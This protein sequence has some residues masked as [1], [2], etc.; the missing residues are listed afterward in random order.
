MEK[1]GVV[2]GESGTNKFFMSMPD[3]TDMMENDYVVVE[4]RERNRKMN[5][6][7]RIMRIGALSSLLTY[8]ASYEAIEKII[9]N[10]IDN[11]KIYAVV[12][13]LGYLEDGKVKFPRN[14][15]FPGTEVYRA[16]KELLEEFY[17][18]GKLPMHIGT[19]L[20]R[21]DVN[22]YLNPLGFMRHVAIIAQTGGGK[23]YTAGVLMEELYDKGA[24]IVV[25]DPHADYVRMNLSH[26]GKTVIP[27]FTVFRNPMSV[28]RYT[29]EV[30]DL[31]VS[32]NDLEPE[33]VADIL[34]FRANAGKMRSVVATAI[35][36]I[37]AEDEKKVITFEE[38][39]TKIEKW[40]KKE[41]KPPGDFKPN[42]AFSTLRVLKR[43]RRK[44][45]PAIFSKNSTPLEK[46]V[47]KKHIAVLDLSGLKNEIQEILVRIFLM[48]IYEMNTK[49]DD[50]TPVF[51]FIEEAHNF[52]PYNRNPIS[53]D[54]I[55]KIAAEGRKFG[56]FLV[57]ISQR[58]QKIDPDV[59]SQM[60]SYII[61]R[62]VNKQ[63]IRALTTAAESLSEDLSSL[64]PSLNPGEAVVVGPVINLPGIVKI[65][66]RKTQEGG[67]D[68]DLISKL[69]D[70][71]KTAGD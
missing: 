5:V 65:R 26:D 27:R 55:K 1:V 43:A 21:E 71:N 9:E 6:V 2:V 14:P 15:P 12:E 47:R 41:E 16:P 19:L 40:A 51:V 11:P 59:L 62:L 38:L 35:D 44:E 67:G 10:E 54:V 50:P 3:D 22:I 18:V 31:T 61:L 25:I 36:E 23:S 8:V 52:I 46:I 45:I 30:E 17:H 7:G 57:I 20:T 60:N 28:G 53:K 70:A 66:N 39:Y 68:I 49:S 37:T 32:L 29:T 69:E 13:T 48:R 64:L 58:P 42:D 63:D 56:V 24:S 34:G 4:V 33:E